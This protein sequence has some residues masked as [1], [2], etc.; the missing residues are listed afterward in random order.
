MVPVHGCESGAGIE[1]GSGFDSIVCSWSPRRCCE[2][3]ASSQFSFYFEVFGPFR[4]HGL[5][6]LLITASASSRISTDEL[7]RPVCRHIVSWRGEMQGVVLVAHWAADCK[8]LIVQLYGST[9]YWRLSLCILSFHSVT[10]SVIL[11]FNL[12]INSNFDLIK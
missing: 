8:A 3:R 11:I 7:C 10:Y 12:Y 6:D 2:A 1:V 9:A 5:S 4:I